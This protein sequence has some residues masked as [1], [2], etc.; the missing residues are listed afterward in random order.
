MALFT[1]LGTAGCI[2]VTFLLDCPGWGDF[3]GSQRSRAELMDIIIPSAIAPCAFFLFSSKLRELAIAHEKLAE[4]ASTDG[5]TG[6]LNRNAFTARVE[7]RLAI[8]DMRQQGALLIVDVDK[9]KRINDSFGHEH[10]DAALRLI[11]GAIR[12]GLRSTDMVGRMGGEEFGAFLPAT[13][14]EQAWAAAER[15]RAAVAALEFAPNG[16][17]Y[18]L[19]VSVG[20]TGFGSVVPFA[21]LYREADRRLYEAKRL[22]RNKVAFSLD[23]PPEALAAA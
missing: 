18:P 3:S 15:V 6:L 22:G 11:A 12:A 8:G 20:G 21:A 19:S 5:L 7:Q 2:A 14:P 17:R 16:R 10:G 23:L 13:S 4:Y 1:I 9:F